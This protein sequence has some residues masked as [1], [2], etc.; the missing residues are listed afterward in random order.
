MCGTWAP[1]V[2]GEI[3]PAET[4]LQ[5]TSGWN[6]HLLNHFIFLDLKNEIPEASILDRIEWPK[7]EQKGKQNQTYTTAYGV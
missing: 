6:Q 2:L 7:G 4:T 5:A 1:S 3:Q